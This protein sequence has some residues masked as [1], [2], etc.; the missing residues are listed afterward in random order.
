MS[1]GNAVIPQISV[2]SH[3]KVYILIIKIYLSEIKDE[4]DGVRLSIPNHLVTQA[5]GF[6][7]DLYAID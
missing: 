5:D 3:N 4:R 2:A 7:I 1:Y 6:N